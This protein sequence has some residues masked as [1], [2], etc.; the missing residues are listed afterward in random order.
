MA[1]TVS[2]TGS[3]DSESPPRSPLAKRVPVIQHL[4]ACRANLSAAGALIRPVVAEGRIVVGN[5][6]ADQKSDVSFLAG[7]AKGLHE[8]ENFAL[9]WIPSTQYI[10]SINCSNGSLQDQ[11][12]ST[13]AKVLAADRRLDGLAQT[14][15]G[16]F[17]NAR[18]KA[19]V[20]RPHVP[21]RGLWNTRLK[22]ILFSDGISSARAV[23][24]TDYNPSPGQGRP[25]RQWEELWWVQRKWQQTSSKKDSFW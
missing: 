4:G 10:G 15:F 12:R 25:G 22:Q 7:I 1:R 14:R 21:V 2:M 13:V 11:G 5:K 3:P 16:G 18:R 23:H 19:P 24:S 6:Q 8:M 17:F 20:V 9:C